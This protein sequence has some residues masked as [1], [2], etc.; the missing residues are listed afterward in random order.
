MAIDD[1]LK[2]TKNFAIRVFKFVEKLPKSKGAD[3]I[4]YQLLK[5][6][7]SV[8]AN[9][10]ATV[11]AKSKADFI[12]KLTIVQEECD[13]SLF[14]LEFIKELELISD[15]ELDWLIKEANELT[16]IFTASLIT[17]KRS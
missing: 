14:W 4:I 10:R 9:H 3:V 17:T 12:N 5:A 15:K 13:E 6:A 11:R 7:S 1:M 8:A 16:A 2:R